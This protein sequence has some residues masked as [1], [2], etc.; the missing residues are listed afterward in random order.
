VFFRE[1]IW[2]SNWRYWRNFRSGIKEGL[3]KPLG[4]LP[5]YI[6]P[7]AENIPQGQQG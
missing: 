4:A 3:Q 7:G 1:F 5:Q 2:K 6:S